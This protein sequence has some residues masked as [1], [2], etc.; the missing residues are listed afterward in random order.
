MDID[1]N[2]DQ[3]DLDTAI[4]RVSFCLDKIE[5]IDFKKDYEKRDIFWRKTIGKRLTY[6]EVFGALVSAEQQLKRVDEV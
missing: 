5:A 6:E 3:G 1:R 4:K 2:V